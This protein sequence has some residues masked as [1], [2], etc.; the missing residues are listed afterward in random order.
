MLVWEALLLTLN[1]VCVE[2]SQD[3]FV[4]TALQELSIT[5]LQGPR[6]ALTGPS[7]FVKGDILCFSVS[8]NLQMML[9][10]W[11]AVL[12]DAKV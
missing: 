5:A 3:N 8:F 2:P 9:Q 7:I 6:A 1:D 4:I 10:S 11:T 12:N